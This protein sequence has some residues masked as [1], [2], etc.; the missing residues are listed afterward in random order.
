MKAKT[1]PMRNDWLSK[2]LAGLILGF[3]IALATTGLIYLLPLKIR[4]SAEAQLIMWLLPPIWLTILSTCFLFRSGLRAWLWLTGA[5]I[6][7]FAIYF[8]FK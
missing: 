1:E 8:L 2:T 7:L 3:F 5:N 4:I 6:I